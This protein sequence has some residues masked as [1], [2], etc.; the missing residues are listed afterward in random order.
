MRLVNFVGICCILAF[1]AV[2]TP[3]YPAI[4][5]E[6]KPLAVTTEKLDEMPFLNGEVWKT[7]AHSEKIAFIWGIGHVVTVETDIMDKRPQ[8]KRS[9]FV[10]KLSEGLSGVSMNDIVAKIDAF[11]ADNPGAG[12]ESVMRVMWDNV[13]KPKIKAGLVEESEADGSKE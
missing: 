1:V 13:V 9:R 6:E 12:T 2:I 3:T 4:S 10:S 8:L 7:M 11:Y 5:A